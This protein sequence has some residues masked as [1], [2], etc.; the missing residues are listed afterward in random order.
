LLGD[1]EWVDGTS[2]QARDKAIARLVEGLRRVG[3]DPRDAFAWDPTRLPYP[4]LTPFNTEDAAVFFGREQEIARL[5]DLLQPTLRRDRGRFVAICGP[6]G[7]GKSS[8]LHA[9]LLPRLYRRPERWIVLPPLRP[10][11]Y[12]VRAL[13]SC[14]AR[15]FLAR[16]HDRS[17][18]EIAAMLEDSSAGLKRLARELAKI[19]RNSDGRVNVLVVIDQAEEL[20]T[21]TDPS[22]GQAFLT[23]LAG[24]L[25][26]DSPVWVVATMR[27]EFLNTNRLVGLAEA[28][29]DWLMVEPLSRGRLA[30]VIA[31]PAGRAGL[32]FQAGLVERMV[33]DTA[34]G[35]ALPLLAYTLRVL[36][37]QT[38]PEGRISAADYERVGGVV[39]TVQRR[40]DGVADELRGRGQGELVVPT[41]LKLAT[42]TGSDEVSR[43]SVRRSTFTPAEQNVVAAFVEARLLTVDQNQA[44]HLTVQIAHAAL[45]DQWPPLRAAI[46]SNRLKLRL[47]ADLERLAA[48]WEQSGRE[49]SYLVRGAR[50]NTLGDWAPGPHSE[51]GSSE[52]QF[53]EAS[54]SAAM[55]EVNAI[56]RL[57]ILSGA[58]VILL[59]ITIITT[60]MAVQ[61]LGG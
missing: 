53:L 8:L 54:R 9:G 50:L 44:G 12:P 4:G 15:S 18:Q 38:G 10:G 58:V 36:Y 35:D 56:R 25:G 14:L 1:T 60:I 45:L 17:A 52:Q 23:M 40:A 61:G 59:I 42:V 24:A 31:G 34:G 33:E 41:L 19:D 2:E 30:E 6:S 46:E 28:V 29:D 48:D 49:E 32:Q 22:E 55:Y 39:G 21:R 20:L 47:R 37:E 27:S 11:R 51:L 3:I 57:R 7:S 5:M 16:G 26:E 43:R 13:T